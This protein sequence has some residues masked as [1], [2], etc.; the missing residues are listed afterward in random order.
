MAAVIGQHDGI[1]GHRHVAVAG[2]LALP[3]LVTGHQL[4]G[5]QLAIV[6]DGVKLIT[7]NQRA[8]V[9]VDHA[10]QLGG[11]A[12]VSHLGLAHRLAVAQQGDAHLAIGTAIEHGAIGDDRGPG[13]AQGQGRL[14]FGQG[15]LQLALIGVE[16]HQT[17]R[18]GQH[19]HATIFDG[20]ARHHFTGD[21]GLPQH[22]PVRFVQGVDHPVLGAEEQ[23][24]ITGDQTAGE[25]GAA[26]VG[27][28]GQVR[29]IHAPQGLATVAIE[30]GHVAITGGGIDV[31][32]FHHGLQLGVE[33]TDAIADGGRPGRVGREGGL[34]HGQGCHRGQVFLGTEQGA[35]L[36]GQGNC[37]PQ[38]HF[39]VQ[40]THP[41]PH[42]L[43]SLAAPGRPSSA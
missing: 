1:A 43:S 2:I 31:I 26:F 3:H 15:P 11:A 6:G 35:A 27:V 17:T 18:G 8:G 23:L 32:L 5:H 30:G 9:H 40:I 38:R 13:T 28:D 42:P 33:I 4:A 7:G 37:H 25:T 19:D 22:F 12:R 41:E 10:V 29:Q 34:D 21:S 16:R 36:Q 24:A 20:G 39:L 14:L